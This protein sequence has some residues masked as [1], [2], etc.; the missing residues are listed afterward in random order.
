MRKG[1]ESGSGWFISYVSV[2]NASW[3][4]VAPGFSNLTESIPVVA[5]TVVPVKD[6]SVTTG[7]YPSPNG[8]KWSFC[9]SVLESILPVLAGVVF[10]APLTVGGM[11]KTIGFPPSGT[12]IDEVDPERTN[13]HV[14][15]VLNPSV[16][17]KGEVVTIV[18]PMSGS[19]SVIT[20]FLPTS[21]CPD[22]SERLVTPV[23]LTDTP[24]TVPRTAA[25][26]VV[27]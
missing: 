6:T 16:V 26:A 17:S 27:V 22:A 20:G 5:P 7:R 21:I 15:V 9:W 18:S 4:E 14:A 3:Y 13:P 25:R 24:N 23:E 8:M 1:I 19:P 12:I 10:S 2:T 11:L